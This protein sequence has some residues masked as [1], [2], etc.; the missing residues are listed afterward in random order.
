MGVV[1][2]KRAWWELEAGMILG[3]AIWEFVLHTYLVV[4]YIH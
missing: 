4:I 3:E 2:D 1:V